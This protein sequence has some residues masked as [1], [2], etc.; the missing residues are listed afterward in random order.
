MPRDFRACHWKLRNLFM[1]RTKFRNA[2]RAISLAHSIKVPGDVSEI[3]KIRV[4]KDVE[5]L[6]ERQ[7]RRAE[8]LRIERWSRLVVLVI[9]EVPITAPSC[10]NRMNWP[11]MSRIDVHRRLVSWS[12][13]SPF[14]GRRPAGINAGIDPAVNLRLSHG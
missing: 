1:P 6:I 4:I 10:W 5:F 3:M 13:S 2:A 12:K 9:K 14:Y 7:L 8:P 11:R